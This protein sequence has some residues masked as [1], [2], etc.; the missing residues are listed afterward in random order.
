MRLFY[1]HIHFLLVTRVAICFSSFF[2]LFLFF[3]MWLWVDG[4][5]YLDVDLGF[6]YRD[7]IKRET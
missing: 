6:D 7:S 1:I 3:L 5:G 2:F 4:V